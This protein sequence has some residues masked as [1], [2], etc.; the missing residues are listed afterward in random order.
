MIPETML[1]IIKILTWSFNAMLTG[2][3]PLTSYLGEQLSGAKNL[4]AGRWKAAFCQLRGDWEFY[5][6]PSFLNF[7]YWNELGRM[8]WKCMAVG[9][10]ASPMKYSRYDKRAPWR[11]TR[12][13]HETYLETLALEGRQ[14]P[15]L[16]NAI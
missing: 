15:A 16:S 12:Q 6:M 3:E 13:T 4:L 5:S 2:I 7:P 9:D 1:A 8:C 14:V 11:A 10:S